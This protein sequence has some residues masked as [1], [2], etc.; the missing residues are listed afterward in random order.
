MSRIDAAKPR[1]FH[2][3]ELVKGAKSGNPNIDPILD[4]K[5][6]ARALELNA[7]RQRIHAGYLLETAPSGP[8]PDLRPEEAQDA[9]RIAEMVIRRIIDWLERHPETTK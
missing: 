8:I 2:F 5:A 3:D 1:Q 9:L 4:D 6:A 7:T